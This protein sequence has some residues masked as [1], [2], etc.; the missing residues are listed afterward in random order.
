[1]IPVSIWHRFF[2]SFSLS[3]DLQLPIQSVSITTKVVSSIPAHGE[4]YSIQQYVIGQWFSL[5]TPVSSTD[6][7]DHHDIT[8]LL[9]KEVL[10]IIIVIVLYSDCFIHIF[11]FI[12]KGLVVMEI[13][14]CHFCTPWYNWKTATVCVRHQL[15][16]N[17]NIFTDNSSWLDF[18]C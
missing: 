13:N 10:N 14:L 1:M 16:I 6:K 4:G 5:G 18:L 11:G 17:N 15:T 3:L 2:L 7:T 8:E 12:P 9:L